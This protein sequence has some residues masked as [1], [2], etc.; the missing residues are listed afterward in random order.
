MPVRRALPFPAKRSSAAGRPAAKNL[1]LLTVADSRFAGPLF[2]S[3]A[4]ADSLPRSLIQQAGQSDACANFPPP[5]SHRAGKP[6]L[7]ALAGHSSRLPESWP[8][9]FHGES[10]G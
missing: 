6:L 8:L 1:H 3:L 9:G 7:Q 2:A 4:S 10:G 5:R